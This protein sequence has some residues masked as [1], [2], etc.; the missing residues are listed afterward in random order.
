MAI[1]KKTHRDSE[2]Q[3]WQFYSG[4]CMTTYRLPDKAPI[5]PGN[6]NMAQCDKEFSDISPLTDGKIAFSTLEDR[7]SAH[8]FEENEILQ[9][10][11]TAT[12]IRITLNRM[13]TFG[14][15]KFGDERVLRSY[16]YAISDLAI[17]GRC[18]CN[19]HADS[20]TKSTGPGFEKLVCGCQVRV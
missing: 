17:G 15:E 13:N 18:K 14:D 1:Y 6:E 16:Y 5:L 19:G 9:D 8:N 3:A 12:S 4:S 11:V 20:C 7:P 10:W 2:W